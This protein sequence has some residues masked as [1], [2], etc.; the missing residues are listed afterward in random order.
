MELIS[1]AQK[2]LHMVL[3]WNKLAGFNTWATVCLIA[4]SYTHLDVYKRQRSDY[5]YGIPDD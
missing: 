1:F 4:V 5:I 3:S 2:L